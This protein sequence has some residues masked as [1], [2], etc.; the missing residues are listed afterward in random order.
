MSSNEL[1]NQLKDIHTPDPISWWPLAP[2][3]WISLLLIIAIAVFLYRKWQQSQSNHPAFLHAQTVLHQLKTRSANKQ[4]LIE[5]IHILRRLSNQFN[6]DKHL[7]SLSTL[8]LI[9]AINYDKVITLSDTTLF[10]AQNIQYQPEV[11]IEAKAWSQFIDDL[12]LLSNLLDPKSKIKRNL[13]Q[14]K[15]PSHV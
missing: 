4:N 11:N 2:G 7:A 15:E 13:Q 9:E 12:I 1:I 3:W 6:P 10:L 5:A 14:A 8:E